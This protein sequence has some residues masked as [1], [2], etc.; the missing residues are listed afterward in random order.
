MTTPWRAYAQ[1]EWLW[2]E[3]W[4]T[5][6]GLRA[7][8]ETRKLTRKRY[9]LIPDTLDANGGTVVPLFGNSGLYNRDPGFVYNPRFEYA[10]ADQSNGSNSDNALTPM[11]SVQYLISNIEG[12]D[13]GTVYLT[14]SEGFLSGG[15][16]E[17]PSGELENFEPEEVKNWE[18]GVQA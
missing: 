3:Q 11:A 8:D 16:S 10:F 4:R 2:T 17:A 14:Y 5:T 18:L 7:T 6:L 9:Q 1:L 15:V 12:I 13:A